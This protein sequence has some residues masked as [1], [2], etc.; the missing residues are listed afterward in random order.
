MTARHLATLGFE[1]FDAGLAP[2]Q[3]LMRD[4]K[5]FSGP[6]T[7]VCEEYAILGG[8]G[9]LLEDIV[10]AELLGPWQTGRVARAAG[11]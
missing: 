4:G 11:P 3:F 9:F 8:L 7:Y 10:C 1:A 5:V 2:V 6:L